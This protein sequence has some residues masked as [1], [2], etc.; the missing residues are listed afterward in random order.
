MEKLEK[1]FM[2]LYNLYVDDCLRLAV[3]F[4]KSI[5]DAEDITQKVFIKLYNELRKNNAN[6]NKTWL[7]K[8]TAN[9]CKNHIKWNKRFIYSDELLENKAGNMIEVDET[10]AALLRLSKKYRIVIYLYYYEGYKVREIA[11]ILHLKEENVRVRIRRGKEKMKE[12]LKE[13]RI[14]AK[15]GGF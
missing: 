4:T 9:E 7:L 14:Y 8:V 12:F 13:E 2:M 5:Q 3:S 1:K 15:E 11:K 10:T 6:Y